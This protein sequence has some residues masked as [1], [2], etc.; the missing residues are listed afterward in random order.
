MAEI[1]NAF[2]ADFELIS[3]LKKHSRPVVRPVLFRKGESPTAVYLVHKGEVLLSAQRGDS[4]TIR[5]APGS[6]LGIPAVV[7]SKPYSLTAEA[8]PGA[9]VQVVTADDF[10]LLMQAEPA[11]AFQVLQ[12]LAAEV[13]LARETLAHA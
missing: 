5:A 6:L 7:G 10:I 3:R 2:I 9:E 11:L 4:F 8:L 13:R 12:I 1:S